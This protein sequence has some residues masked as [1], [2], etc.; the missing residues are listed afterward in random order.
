MSS[1]IEALWV[2]YDDGC[3]FCCRCARWLT[4]QDKWV[5][6]MCLPRSSEG[7]KKWFGAA[8]N[9]HDELLVLDSKGGLY[10]G[11]DAFIICLWALVRFRPWAQLARNESI[12]RHARTLF[13]WLSNI[14]HDLNQ[15]F[16]LKPE[17]QPL[18]DFDALAKL[19]LAMKCAAPR[20][21]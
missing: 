2:M 14:R 17:R 7:A 10:R 6:I 8:M 19:P 16:Q 5:P 9:P 11:P 20:D 21:S 15:A 1:A 12:R 4:L 13:F 18:P 3:G